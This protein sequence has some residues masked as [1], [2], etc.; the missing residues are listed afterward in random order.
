M[1][2]IEASCY[3]G[4]WPTVEAVSQSQLITPAKQARCCCVNEDDV[5]RFNIHFIRLHDSLHGGP[6]SVVRLN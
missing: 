5:F 2:V 3:G 1:F 4:P 6:R